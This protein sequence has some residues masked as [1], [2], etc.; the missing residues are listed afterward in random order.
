MPPLPEPEPDWDS[1]DV[2][3]RMHLR[4]NPI[5]TWKEVNALRAINVNTGDMFHMCGSKGGKHDL[6]KM[7]GIAYRDDTTLINQVDMVKV[8]A[9]Q[10]IWL[11]LDKS[12]SDTSQ[13][14]AQLSAVDT[15]FCQD[16]LGEKG[17]AFTQFFTPDSGT[18]GFELGNIEKQRF[19]VNDL[20]RV[21]CMV[22]EE[23]DPLCTD[24]PDAGRVIMLDMDGDD[25][26]ALRTKQKQSKGSM[27][28]KEWQ[29]KLLL[30]LR[31]QVLISAKLSTPQKE[32]C[33]LNDIE[34]Y[35]SHIC[36]YVIFAPDSIRMDFNEAKKADMA[37]RS[38]LF[39]SIR[40]GATFGEAIRA[41]E[42]M[43]HVMIHYV[44]RRPDQQ[45]PKTP[46]QQRPQANGKRAPVTPVST[47]KRSRP[48]ST[49]SRVSNPNSARNIG[50]NA[51]ATPPPKEKGTCNFFNQT[52]VCPHKACRF[53]HLCSI[54]NNK[55][56][57]G[58]WSHS[59]GAPKK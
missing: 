19:R 27:S 41:N 22:P 24:D 14:D 45:Q 52:G 29:R 15:K 48:A 10:Q 6:G 46:Q 38:L 43:M 30:A 20:L 11:K 35:W 57:K 18:L 21:K 1:F 23:E 50:G 8:C 58:A 9:L 13:C 42:A 17:V 54:C 59:G 49:E 40:A 32:W 51:K 39:K 12:R 3:L 7:V 33:S 36:Q 5:L 47:A 56:C 28:Y 31:A 2:E 37:F 55:N 26:P 53:L 16:R 25:G 44:H 34:L 4:S